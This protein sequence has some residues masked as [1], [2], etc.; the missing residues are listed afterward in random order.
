MSREQ[1]PS[2]SNG[3]DGASEPYRRLFDAICYDARVCSNC[4]RLRQGNVEADFYRTSGGSNSEL[5]AEFCT[6]DGTAA[7]WVDGTVS[8]SWSHD[9]LPAT[10]DRSLAEKLK[11]LFDRIEEFGDVDVD[12][13][14]GLD[15]AL[16]AKS[17]EEFSG[18][19]RECFVRGLEAAL[20]S[21]DVDLS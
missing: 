21:A 14:E 8:E 17:S 12:R 13:Y 10:G 2:E 9:P 11:R 1:S 6:H 5:R 3:D 4:F 19:D 18:R 7:P 15:A 16:D 20:D